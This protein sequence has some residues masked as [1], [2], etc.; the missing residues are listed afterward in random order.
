MI[1]GSVPAAVAVDGAAHEL[2]QRGHLG[3]LRDV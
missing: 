2:A 3:E 1:A